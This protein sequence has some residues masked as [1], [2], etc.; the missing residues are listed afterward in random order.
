MLTLKIL[1]LLFIAS[2][3][4]GCNG[5]TA[6]YIPSEVLENKQEETFDEGYDTYNHQEK[7]KTA[8]K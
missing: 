2:S 6:P 8:K 5:K 4:V 1:L 3:L 7:I